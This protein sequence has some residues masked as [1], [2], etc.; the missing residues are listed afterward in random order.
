MNKGDTVSLELSVEEIA[1]K[2]QLEQNERVLASYE[3]DLRAIDAEL[4]Q[5]PKISTNVCAMRIGR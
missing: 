4:E 1:L 2:D 3:N 5:H